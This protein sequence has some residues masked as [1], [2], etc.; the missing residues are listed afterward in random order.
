MAL[1]YDSALGLP[2]DQI[3]VLLAIAPFVQ[4]VA[5]PLWTLIVDRHPNLH[6]PLMSVLALVGGASIM[7][8]MFIP[9]WFANN[10]QDSTETGLSLKFFATASFALL[11]AFFGQPLQVLVDSAVLKILGDQKILY[12]SQRLWGSVS[13]GIN[14][15][16][17]G[18]W[19]GAAGIDKAFY[20]FAFG[21]IAFAL[22]AMFTRFPTEEG[23]Q[24]ENNNEADEHRSLLR[25]PMSIQ[26][27]YQ[28]YQQ[29]QLSM[30]NS[31]SEYVDPLPRR[32]SMA[33]YAN[34][35]ILEDGIDDRRLGLLRTATSMLDVQT[36]AS[37]RIANMDHLPP[38]G[39]ALSNIPTVESTLAAFADLGRPESK[40][41]QK[42]TL[43]TPR[44]W[45]FLLTMLLLGISY[46]MISQ[47]LFLFFCNDLEIDS[48]LIGWIGPIGG[49]AEVTTFW[50]SNKLLEEFTV[51]SLISLAHIGLIVR[52]LVYSTLSP[53]NSLSTVLALGMHFASGS[54]YALAWSTAVSEVDTFFPPDQR[55]IAQGIL[56]ALFNGLGF[57]LGC[58]L[59]G[60]V[61]GRWGA[62][63]LIH[64]A[65]CVA[66]VSLLVFLGGRNSRGTSNRSSGNN[67]SH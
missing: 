4:S 59:G 33:S 2:S 42:S 62:V 60:I 48:S 55:A 22:L 20:I 40:P 13:N 52:N 17:V 45:S 11:F 27:Q 35:E 10:Q 46:A 21:I 9:S 54:G 36:E 19:I 15:L 41:P 38:I 29:Q 50:V 65:S 56:A 67:T 31:L 3:G 37:Q 24:W 64:T 32:D 47:F 53:G 12:G 14:I 43:T 18:L 30:H 61:Y 57:G 6:G 49:I 39:L 51:S 1:F 34:T 66:A 16:L 23:G 5:C 28:H 63:A 8:L 25:K 44:V 7:S 26:Q 58:I